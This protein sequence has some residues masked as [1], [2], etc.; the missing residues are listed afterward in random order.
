MNLKDFQD[1]FQ[2]YIFKNNF[3]KDLDAIVKPGGTILSNPKALDIHKNGYVAGLTEALSEEYECCWWILGDDEFFN[4]CKEF[5]LAYPSKTYNLMFYGKEFPQFLKESKYIDEAPFLYDLA[6]F[7][8]KN[9]STFHKKQHE[10]YSP[11]QLQELFQDQR[12]KMKFAESVSLFESDSAI[13]SIWEHIKNSSSQDSFDFDEN[14][15]E[16]ILMYKQKQQVYS[17]Q[18]TELQFKL[19]K[20]LLKSENLDSFLEALDFDVS[21]EDIQG[22]F[23]I[24]AETEILEA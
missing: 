17:Y 3:E 5:V 11:K 10:S 13:F 23:G 12:Q 4:V 19:F 9:S 2:K 20:L 24:V 1:S 7:E 14:V 15:S 21:P 18:I 16:Y 22:L 6:L 8:Q